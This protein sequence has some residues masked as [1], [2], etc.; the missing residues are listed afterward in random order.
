M[1]LNVVVQRLVWTKA[2]Q[3]AA[4]PL[5]ARQFFEQLKTS[6]AA[7]FLNRASAEQARI[8][9]ALFSGSQV[10][11]ELLLAHPDW[12]SACLV[13][14][15]LQHQRQKQGL[16]RDLRRLLGPE[17][18]ALDYPGAMVKVR[19]FKQR[20][21]LRIAA[22]DLARLA[23]VTEITLE[24]SNVADLCLAT[25]FDLS[26]QQL[27]Q[28][29]GEAY[30]LDAESAW[31]K[32][33]FAIFGMGK[34]GGQELNYSSDV[35]LLFVYSEEGHLFKEPPRKSSAGGKG[36]T[37]YQFFKRLAELFINE[38]SRLTSQGALAEQLRDVLC[39]MGPNVGTNDVDQG[40]SCCR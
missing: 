38:V 4:D 7:A 31:R 14:E 36:M 12:L 27:A 18:K 24:I 22:R 6:G 19:E 21:M 5:R 25:V 20:E 30:H 28:R 23:D 3:A 11:S 40:P 37:N 15:H 34:L 39:A 33:E 32:T 9:A 26:R 16:E 13:A 10:L 35:D 17:L 2:I 29:L 1:R 8:L